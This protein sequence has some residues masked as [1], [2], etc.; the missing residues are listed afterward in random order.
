MHPSGRQRAAL[1]IPTPPNDHDLALFASVASYSTE[2][3][4]P[5]PQWLDSLAQEQ[6]IDMTGVAARLRQHLSAPSG[7]ATPGVQLPLPRPGNVLPDGETAS[8]GPSG[9]L[10]APVAPCIPPPPPSSANTEASQASADIP[11]RGPDQII[12]RRI[13]TVD[14]LIT[15]WEVALV[16]DGPMSQ[17][18][19]SSKGTLDAAQVNVLSKTYT[20]WR[21]VQELS[22]DEFA[23]RFECLAHGKVP[24]L[25]SIRMCIEKQRSSFNT[26]TGTIFLRNL[27]EMVCVLNG[28]SNVPRSTRPQAPS[29][30]EKKPGRGGVR[31]QRRGRTTD[32]RV[33][34]LVYITSAASAVQSLVVM[35]LTFAT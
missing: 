25:Y 2:T 4:P 26:A 5:L 12:C 18:K 11:L 21:K 20:V 28:T 7:D 10:T 6:L 15:A 19:K 14:E 13:K 8:Q 29:F 1:F 22:R 31:A 27:G 16:G 30:F 33:C 17:Y 32:H 35:L 34:R 23:E 24:S 9:G 3:T